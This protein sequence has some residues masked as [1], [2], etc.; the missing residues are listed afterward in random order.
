MIWRRR[1]E[2]ERWLSCN[3][4]IGREQDVECVDRLIPTNGHQLRISW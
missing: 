4:A 2:E 3:Q 1:E